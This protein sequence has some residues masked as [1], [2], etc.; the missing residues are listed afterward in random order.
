M[1][2]LFRFF[3]FALLVYMALSFLI[4]LLALFGSSQV[5]DFQDVSIVDS[6]AHRKHHHRCWATPSSG[7]TYCADYDTEEK[8]S[9]QLGRERSAIVGKKEAYH[10]YWGSV[11]RQLATQNKVYV[12]HT[13]D[14]LRLVAQNHG[15]NQTE[16]AELI[17][18]F[19]QDIPY[20][21][22]RGDS[23]EDA[24]Y[25]NHSCV[26]NTTHGILA[27]YE[28]LHTLDGDCDTRSV[29]LF[30]MLD[31][32]GFQPLVMISYEYAHAMLALNIKG[33]GSYVNFKRDKYYFWE[34]TSKNWLAG[35]LPADSK[36]IDYW[37]IALA[38]EL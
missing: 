3:G 15:L 2:S 18:S 6:L 38:H 24:D 1:R 9:V 12:Q 13:A 14:S 10:E 25:I 37:K 5:N 27:P 17:V 28:F 19:V 20:T 36:N 30:V 4:E 7:S 26:G 23:C 8:V 16:Y 34:T 21:L 35:M 31:Y 32:L 11:Y 22:I 33:S 29:L